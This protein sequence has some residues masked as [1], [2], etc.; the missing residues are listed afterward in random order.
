MLIFMFQNIISQP[1]LALVGYASNV[2]VVFYTSFSG[3]TWAT[4]ACDEGHWWQ[5]GVLQENVWQAATPQHVTDP[6]NPTP[7]GRE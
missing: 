6:V 5:H 2:S 1:I 3:A 7:N 4:K